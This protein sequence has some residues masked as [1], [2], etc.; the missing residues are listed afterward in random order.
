MEETFLSFR[1]HF[2]FLALIGLDKDKIW[3]GEMQRRKTMQDV[4]K[5]SIETEVK[6]YKSFAVFF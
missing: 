5:G 4:P 1:L 2:G 6:I 3:R